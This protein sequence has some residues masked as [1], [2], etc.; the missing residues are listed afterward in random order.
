M[1]AF[2]L[3]VEQ[4]SGNG[5]LIFDSVTHPSCP[6]WTVAH[7]DAVLGD[8]ISPLAW[9]VVGP[10]FERSQA[11]LW[12]SLGVVPPTRDRRARFSARLNGRLHVGLSTLRAAAMRIPG[13]DPTR[14]EGELGL[15][16]SELRRTWNDRA[17]HP[18][19]IIGATSTAGRSPAW[20]LRQR[21]AVRRAGVLTPA[22]SLETAELIHRVELLRRQLTPVLRTH[23]LLRMATHAS[24]DRLRAD[25]ADDDLA[26]GLLADLPEL[27][28][29]QPSL[30][31]R[32]MAERARSLG[33][34]HERD[35]DAFVDRF[36]HRGV[37]E[38]DPTVPVWE[39]Q[40]PHLRAVV[41]R[42]IATSPEDP[43]RQ[44]REARVRARSALE[45]VGRLRRERIV[46]D[47]AFAR[48]FSVLGE[49]SKGDVA[50]LTNQIRRSLDELARRTADR[51]DPADT[52]MLSWNE[53]RTLAT[54]AGSI[55]ADLTARRLALHGPIE[56]SADSTENF[57]RTLLG[58]AA[59]PGVVTGT[60]FVVHDPADELPVGDVLVAHATDTAWTPLF[61]GLAAVVTDTG[62][63]L[64]HSSIVARDL[65]I[66][67]VV[68][69]GNAT[70][71]VRTGDRARVDG[72][73]GRVELLA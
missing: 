41:E 24:L 50:L 36:G 20:V 51:C 40:R 55:D 34:L 62:G 70:T 66:P 5:V 37:N 61:L 68:G 44:G 13:V 33:R 39:S 38:L 54:D 19:A 35:L 69:T 49:H 3:E 27:E 17:W 9:T 2:D 8:R 63:V 12:A 45:R 1:R 29:T 46:A 16:P 72:D 10:A 6:E 4:A 43:V 26:F 60:A 52:P 31:L 56:P 21:R 64:S 30:A 22:G 42:L 7:V 67:A 11:R 47:A 28:A 71:V 32:A 73:V 18:L 59:S 57:S 58:V 48:R 14:T 65:G 15:P 53:F 25:C 23:A